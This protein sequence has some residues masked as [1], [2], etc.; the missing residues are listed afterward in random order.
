MRLCVYLGLTLLAMF[1]STELWA[2]GGRRARVCQS[3]GTPSTS[4][5]STSYYQYP[6]ESYY[7]TA[8][9][10]SHEYRYQQYQDNLQQYYPDG[11]LYTHRQGVSY[12][13]VDS[14]FVPH[15][16]YYSAAYDNNDLPSWYR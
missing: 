3:T 5:Y 9:A 1:S 14:Y 8:T 10:S 13:R 16:P 11:V 12:D 6:Y 2:R 7:P 4:C 15:R